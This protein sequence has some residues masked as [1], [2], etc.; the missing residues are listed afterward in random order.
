MDVFA[1][2]DDAEATHLWVASEPMPGQSGA[3]EWTAEFRAIPASARDWGFLLDGEASVV[4]FG[5]PAPLVGLC[6]VITQPTA[7]VTEA[8]LIVDA[9]FAVPV[10]ETTWGRVKALYRLK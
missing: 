5:A 6:E 7:T 9:E 1:T 10:D 4:L 3:F 2:F 8:V